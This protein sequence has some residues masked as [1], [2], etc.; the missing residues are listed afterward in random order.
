MARSSGSSSTGD[1]LVYLGNCLGHGAEVR[2]AIDELLGFR[3]QILARPGM[4]PFDIAYLRGAQE[5][6]WQ[7]L[8]QLQFAPNPR[9][10]LGWM[11]EHGVGA[12]LSAYG[13][14]IQQGIVAARDGP[15]AHHPLDQPAAHR[16]AGSPRPL[17]PAER[18]AP[19]RIHR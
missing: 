7:K 18:A 12:T 13:G 2:G 4:F 16:H 8:L 19:R 15:L 1:R 3:R 6:M 9:E 11:L 5:E 17:Q 14:S 10:V